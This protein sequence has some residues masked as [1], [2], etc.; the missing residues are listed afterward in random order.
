[1]NV[2]KK[3]NHTKHSIIG[4]RL[5]DENKVDNFVDSSTILNA[6]DVIQERG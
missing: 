2:Q 6:K 5:R 4:F 3:F 1:M